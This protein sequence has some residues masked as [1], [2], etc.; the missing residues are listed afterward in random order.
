MDLRKIGAGLQ[1][2]KFKTSDGEEYTAWGAI[3]ATGEP[4]IDAIEIFGDDQKLGEFITQQSEDLT[5]NFNAIT[6]DVVQAVTGNN[7][8][9]SSVGIE[10]AAGTDSE[11]NP[12]YVEVT[13][14]SLAR[15]EDGT[16][17]FFI[18]KWYKVQIK[19]PQISQQNGTEL[20]CNFEGIAYKTSEDVE[21][22]SLASARVS[23]LRFET[24][25]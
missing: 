17:G 7:Y 8:S 9:S 23:L 4:N 11:Q 15:A 25:A 16:A 22:N 13:A 19:N 14:K 24:V 18:K 2:V 20:T 1:E 21:G 5:F 12:P 6:F 10:I 3:E